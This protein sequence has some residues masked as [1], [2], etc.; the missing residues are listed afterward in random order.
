MKLEVG[1]NELFGAL[2]AVIGVVERR[3]TLP[4][5]S[6][7]LLVVNGDEMVVTGTDLE[8]ELVSLSLIHISEPT[9]PY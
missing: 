1:R 2:Q 5:L 6:N 8:I 9:R 3:Q 4:V 7:F